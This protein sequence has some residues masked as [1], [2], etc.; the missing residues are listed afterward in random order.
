[1]KYLIRKD[2]RKRQIISS[3]ELS[4]V[5]LKSVSTNLALDRNV[6][7]NAFLNLIKFPKNSSFIQ[8]KNRCLVT[9]R[10][11]AILHKYRISRIVYKQMAM[12]KKLPSGISY[13]IW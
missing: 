2:F 13:A 9:C 4:K 7:D 11:R 12:E 6:R 5:V 8:A 10:G 1:M 3:K